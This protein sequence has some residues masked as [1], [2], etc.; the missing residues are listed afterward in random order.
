MIK[1]VWAFNTEMGC[2]TIIDAIITEVLYT[3][4]V[5]L[6]AFCETD[7]KW[8][9]SGFG[10][11][12]NVDYMIGSTISR[13]TARYIDSFVLVVEAKLEWPI[14]GVA[15]VIAEAGCLHKRR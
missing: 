8:E 11:T 3:S 14:S 10:Y 5:N 12:G 1:E 4:K 6:T 7:N 9:G 13:D 15:Q 2:R